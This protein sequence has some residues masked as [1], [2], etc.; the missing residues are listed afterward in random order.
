MAP[1]ASKQKRLAEKAAKG[2]AKSKGKDTD[3]ST[4]TS[5][6]TGSANG[7]AASTPMTSLSA[8]TS[9]EDL[10]AMEKLKI[11]TDRSVS[12]LSSPCFIPISCPRGP[13]SLL[14][15]RLP[16]RSAAGVLVSD[17]K[18][19]DIK[20][21]SFTLSFHGRLLIENAEISFNY[22]NRY[23][24]L[25]QNGSGKVIIPT[26]TRSRDTSFH[27]LSPRLIRRL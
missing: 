9:K 5:T 25:G 11:A 20:I 26:C 12:R 16:F 24:L 3:A 1:S 6:P 19:R 15:R 4:S 17:A 27:V 18:G 23:G 2:S 14:T 22:G 10:S 7:S 8:N 21:D 13:R